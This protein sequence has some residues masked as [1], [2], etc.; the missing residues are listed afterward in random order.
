MPR[1]VA[2]GKAVSGLMSSSFSQFQIKRMTIYLAVIFAAA[3]LVYLKDFSE[4]HALRHALD[5]IGFA[6]LAYGTYKNGLVTESRSLAGPLCVSNRWRISSCLSRN[7]YNS[8]R[9]CIDQVSRVSANNSF[10][11]NTLHSSKRRH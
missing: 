8:C 10:K 1:S 9:V 5:G 4:G 3:A 11:P 7:H 2:L 6:L